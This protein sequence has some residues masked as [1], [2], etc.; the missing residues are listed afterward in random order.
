MDRYIQRSVCIKTKQCDGKVLPRNRSNRLANVLRFWC[1]VHTFAGNFTLSHVITPGLF[2]LTAMHVRLILQTGYSILCQT[3][4]KVGNPGLY[5]CQ[6]DTQHCS[7]SSA[8]LQYLQEFDSSWLSASVL[9]LGSACLKELRR[10][11]AE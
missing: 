3:V 9:P 1:E 11:G 6:S 7:S 8:K 10:E 2:P 5:I 4:P